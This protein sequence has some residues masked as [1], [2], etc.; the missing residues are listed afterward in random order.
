MTI[1]VT[2]VVAPDLPIAP[3]STIR[4]GLSLSN[5]DSEPV[6]TPGCV[7]AHGALLVLRQ[8]DFTILQSSDNAWTVIGIMPESLLGQIVSFVIGEDA[9][10]QLGQLI[11]DEAADCNP[12]FLMRMPVTRNAGADSNK[13]SV[14][15][16][17]AHTIGGVVILEFEPGDVATRVVPDSNPDAN[18]DSNTDYYPLVKKTVARL[19]KTASI[20]QFCDTV[21]ADIRVLTGLDRVMVYKFHADGHG[22]VLAESKTAALASWLGLHYPAEDIPKP[23]RDMFTKTW[24]RPVPDV[25]AA[26]SE[27]IPLFN[28]DTGR[29]LD[30][31]Y[32]ALRGVSMMYTEYLRNMGVQAS[33]TMAIRR[34]GQLW[35]LIAG[36]HYAGPRHFSYQMRAACEFLAQVVSLQHQAADDREHLVYRQAI[37][38]AHQNLLSAAASEGGLITFINGSPSL[39]NGIGAGGA[40]LYYLERWWRIGDTPDENDLENLGGWLVETVFKAGKRSL[41]VTDHLAAA[42]PPA[43]EFSRIASGLMAVPLSSDGS[44]LIVWFRPETMQTVHWAGDPGDKPVVPGPYGPRL[45]PRQSFALFTESVHQKCLPWKPLE[46]EAAA[47]LR[48]LTAEFLSGQKQQRSIASGDL[49]RSN[50]ALDAFAYVASHD[51]KEPLRGIHQY[52]HQLR[53]NIAPVDDESRRKLDGLVRLT[54]RMD[55]LLD[56]LLHFSRAGGN[57]LALEE[58]DLNHVLNDALDSLTSR[59]SAARSEISIPRPLPTTRCDPVKCRQIFVNLLSNALKYNDGPEKRTEVGYIAIDDIKER[60][61]CPAGAEGYTIYYVADNGIGIHMKQFKHIF[62]LF[63]RLHGRDSY[64]GGTGAGLTIVRKLV[65]QHGGQVWVN[66]SPQQGATFYF[67]MPLSRASL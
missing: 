31:T 59:L 15:D 51:L 26:L 21:T 25:S 34:N 14:L 65:E 17:H 20:Q 23:A 18:S 27:M 43:A 53:E 29:P 54:L 24:I 64:G 2:T 7:Q 56:S 38:R 32:C 45:T 19:Q 61:G 52:A 57:E 13:R 6:Q 63:K 8:S 1:Q 60:P 55:S 5:C 33:L 12:Q 41:Y 58:C 42:Y 66:S 37:E 47:A 50:E 44:D 62:K 3:Y 22:E 30:M 28:P 48:V 40:A 39:L 46:I 35:G 67:T 11:L 4:H 49:A 16:V 9:Q 10:R 36:H